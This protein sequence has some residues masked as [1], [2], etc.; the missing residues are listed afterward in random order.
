MAIEPTRAQVR[1]L[2]YATAKHY[3][4]KSTVSESYVLGNP[5]KKNGK[6]VTKGLGMDS[7]VRKGFGGAVN[8]RIKEARI[9]LNKKRAKRFQFATFGAKT[10]VGDIIDKT[11]E[12]IHA[13]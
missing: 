11:H 8:S 1:D 2:I 7:Q 13:A 5:I 4:K 10:K 3:S 9:K 12:K 6:I